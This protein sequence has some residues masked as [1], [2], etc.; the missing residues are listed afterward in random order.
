M[1]NKYPPNLCVPKEDMKP[2]DKDYWKRK[3]ILKR[4]LNNAVY[5]IIRCYG[6]VLRKLGKQ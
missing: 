3:S 6:S 1:K 2:I 5:K 4:K